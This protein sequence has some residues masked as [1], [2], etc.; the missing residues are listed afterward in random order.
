LTFAAYPRPA[1]DGAIGEVIGSDVKKLK[2]L[3]IGNA[4]AWFYPAEN[5][6]VLWECYL[7]GRFRQH[8]DPCKEAILQTLWT[9]FERIL[10]DLLPPVER[11]YTT[12]E[13]IYKRPVFAKFLATQ[14]FRKQGNITFIKE[15]EQLVQEV[16][17]V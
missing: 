13:P 5:A 2:P 11:I 17:S 7:T 9:G 14:G 6:L 8:D 16:T 15:V 10:L 4:Q 1:K 3:E 12:Y